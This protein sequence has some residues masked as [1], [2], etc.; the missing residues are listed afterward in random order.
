[1]VSHERNDLK[2]GDNR[3]YPMEKSAGCEPVP[4]DEQDGE[5]YVVK[6]LLAFWVYREG[7]RGIT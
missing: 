1:M 4:L 7:T 5:Q 3:K 6:V 2:R